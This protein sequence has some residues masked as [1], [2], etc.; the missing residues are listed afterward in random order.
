MCHKCF[1]Y[2]VI[3][4]VWLMCIICKLCVIFRHMLNM[5]SNSYSKHVCIIACIHTHMWNMHRKR[6]TYVKHVFYYVCETYRVFLT[7][8]KHMLHIMLYTSLR[9][10]CA[11]NFDLCRCNTFLRTYCANVVNLKIR[12]TR[13]LHVRY[14]NLRS[15]LFNE[16]FQIVN[17][18]IVNI[19]VSL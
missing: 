13:F 7:Y 14:A 12:I 16:I 15:I 9:L 2:V 3:E 17:L 19:H 18:D 6:K 8:V 11:L 10:N 1:T 5:S 4:H